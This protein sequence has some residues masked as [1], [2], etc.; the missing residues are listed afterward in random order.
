MLYNSTTTPIYHRHCE[1]GQARTQLSMGFAAGRS[2]RLRA[3][4]VEAESSSGQLRSIGL[5]A[6]NAIVL[7]GQPSVGG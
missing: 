7:A 4:L 6:T 2:P 5:I 3:S 1:G